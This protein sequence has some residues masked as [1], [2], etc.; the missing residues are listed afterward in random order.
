MEEM[1]TK[2]IYDSS[3]SPIKNQKNYNGSIDMCI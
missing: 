3:V 2:D 1:L